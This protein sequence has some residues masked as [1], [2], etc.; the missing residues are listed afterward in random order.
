LNRWLL[1]LIQAGL[2]LRALALVS[3]PVRAVVAVPVAAA[4]NSRLMVLNHL[5]W[6]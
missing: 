4:R 2:V 6:A 3:V 1:L 5:V